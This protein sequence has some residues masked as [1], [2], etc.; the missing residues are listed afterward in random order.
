MSRF[1]VIHIVV[2]AFTLVLT[3]CAKG[4]ST[5]FLAPKEERPSYQKIILLP[6]NDLSGS[7]KAQTTVE[8]LMSS[9]I[10][11]HYGIEVLSGNTLKKKIAEKRLDGEDYS[12]RLFAY[13][14]AQVLDADTVIFGDILEYRYR[15]WVAKNKGLAEDPIVCIGARIV[16]GK[17][18]AVIWSSTEVVGDY[19]L[20]TT[21]SDPLTGVALRVV[22]KLVRSMRINETK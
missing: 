9:Q 12:S 18:G 3:S 21:G 13:K 10:K 8:T 17:T 22:D 16:N 5:K 19:G 6:F 14:A 2:L 20:F 1:S 11:S 7:E 15:R 4:Y